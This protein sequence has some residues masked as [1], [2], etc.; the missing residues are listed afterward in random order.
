M[1]NFNEDR[2]TGAESAG[3]VNVSLCTNG[4]FFVPVWAVVE[5]SDWSVERLVGGR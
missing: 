2:I 4:K 1:G 3:Q 5:I